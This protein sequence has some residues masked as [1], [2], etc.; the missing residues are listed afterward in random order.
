VRGQVLTIEPYTQLP[1]RTGDDHDIRRDEVV[2]LSRAT[3]IEMAKSQLDILVAA[4]VSQLESISRVNIRPSLTRS[5]GRFV[6]KS[7]TAL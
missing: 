1:N 3:M 5:C 4:I 2:A 7:R 6:D